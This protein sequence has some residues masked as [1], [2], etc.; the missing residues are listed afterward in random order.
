MC[1]YSEG[2]VLGRRCEGIATANVTWIITGEELLGHCEL[3]NRY[4]CVLT[5]IGDIHSA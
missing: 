3:T 1:S 4:E 2:F 5:D